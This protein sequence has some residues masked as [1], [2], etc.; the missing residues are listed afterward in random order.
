MIFRQVSRRIRGVAYFATLFAISFAGCSNSLKTGGGASTSSGAMP[1]A[2]VSY[3]APANGATPG[4][5]SSDTGVSVARASFTAAGEVQLPVGY[6]QWEHV[7]TRD[8]AQGKV[9]IIDGKPT[10]TPEVLNAYVEPTA[11]TAYQKTGEWPDGSQM[12]KEFSAVRV[13]A[14]CRPDT[15]LCTTK[16]GEGIFETGYVGLGMMVKDEKRFPDAPGHWGFFEFGHHPPPYDPVSAVRPVNQCTYCHVALASD[17]DYVISRAH[18]G[19][20]RENSK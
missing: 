4:A 11:F 18:I 9:S 6:R 10:K 2:S 1:D 15:Y 19:L 12:V 17:T 20:A 8:N 13:G 3:A 16:F 5:Q 7:G 14:N